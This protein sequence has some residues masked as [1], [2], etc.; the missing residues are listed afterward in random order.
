M[1]KRFT[2][3][4]KLKHKKLI[5]QLFKE[6][7]TITKYPIQLVYLKLAHHGKFPIK[8]GFSVTKKKFKR[9]VDRN[10]IKRRMREVYRLNKQYV[11]SLLNDK[12]IFM[13]IYLD[14]EIQ[15]SKSIH[16]KMEQLLKKFMETI[17]L[18]I[19]PKLGQ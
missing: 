12:Y 1:N 4:E 2:K 19:P 6:G 17:K 15:S 18:I 9:A 10:L 7:K 13:F 16:L 5:A 8:A 3:D 14:S 11:Y